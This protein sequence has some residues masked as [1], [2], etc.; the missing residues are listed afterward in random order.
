[1]LAIHNHRTRSQHTSI[2]L[3]ER[4]LNHAVGR[5]GESQL[6]LISEQH[7]ISGRLSGVI[8]FYFLEFL[9]ALRKRIERASMVLK[10]VPKTRQKIDCALFDGLLRIN[11]ATQLQKA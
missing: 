9:T 1:M 2:V 3:R 5:I 6:D 4:D 7:E 10:Q 8:N 11:S